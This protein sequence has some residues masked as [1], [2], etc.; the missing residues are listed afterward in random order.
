[1]NQSQFGVSIG[2]PIMKNRTFYF[3]N[4]EK[5]ALDQTGLTTISDTNAAVIN[6]RLA[7]V[8]YGGPAVATGIYPNPVD[9]MN[10]LAKIDHQIRRRASVQRTLRPLRC[11]STNSRGAGGLSAPSASAD[12]DNTDQVLAFSHA[13]ILSSRSLLETRAQ[14]AHSDLQA[15]PSDAIGPA[16]AS[17]AWR[18]LAPLSGSPTARAEPHVSGRQQL[19]ARRAAR[20]RCGPASTSCTT[21][22]TSPTRGR[23][24]AAT[25]FRRWRTSCPAPT[26]TPASRRPSATPA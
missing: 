20:I 26:T 3:G 15:P 7:A 12:L 19:F 22:T 13:L 18:H 23:R 1:M 16:V 2:G 17:R 14:V 6:A 25:R 21:T 8:G 24:A 5:R 4:V 10:V 11:A 9:T